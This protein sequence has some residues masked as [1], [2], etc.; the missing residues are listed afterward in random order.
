MIPLGFE[1]PEWLWALLLLVPVVA[2]AWPTRRVLSRVR[3]GAIL[4]ARLALLLALI[5]AL[6]GMVWYRH[7]DALAVVF[8]VDRSASLGLDGQE[9]GLKWVQEALAHQG[10][11]DLAG[12]VVFGAEAMVEAEPRPELALRGIEARPSP[13]Q[14][15]LAAG[16]RLGA[17]LIP[18]DRNGRIV[19]ISDGDETRG[20]AAAQVLLS[21]TEAVSLAVVPL[22]RASGPDVWLEDLLSPPRVDE[23]ASYE[24]RVVARASVPA[25]GQLRLYRN[26]EHLG[27]VP[28]TLR[29]DRAEVFTFRQ[30]ARVAGL[31]RYRAVFEPDPGITDVIPQNNEVMSTTQIMGRPR[32]LLVEG[33]PS[34]AKPLQAALT[35]QGFLVEVVDPAG[36]PAGPSG[37]RPYTALF[38][39]DVPAYTLS[40]RQQ[41]AVRSYVRDM[42]RGLVMIGGEKSFG[43]GGY[44]KSPIEQALP[45]KMDV[46]DK[47]RFPRVATVI[48]LDKSCSMG[49]G[50][51][52]ALGMAKEAGIQTVELLS[53]RDELGV[54]GFD[55]AASWIVPLLPLEDKDAVSR[56]IASI[57]SGGGTEIY[58]ALDR[59]IK[60]LKQ[61][62]AAVRHLILISD[63]GT[64]PGD[65]ETLIRGARKNDITLTS[66]AVGTYADQQ[67]MRDFAKWGGG[68]YYLV[69][70][71]S[72]IPAVFTREMMLASGSFL[73]EDPFTPQL[74]EPSD[75]TRGIAQAELRT[76]G[77]FVA[78]TAK[79]R[80]TLAMVAPGAEGQSALPLLAHWRF[81][82]G[83]SVAFTSDAKARWAKDWLGA[84]VYNRLWGQ[85]GRWTAGDIAGGDL[86][87]SAEIR[88]GELVVSV[89]A[90]DERGDF[91]NFLDGEARVI[92]PDLTVRPLALKQVSP[93]R[94]EARA[95]VDQ[96]GSWLAG[97]QLRD[98]EAV[99]GQAVAEAVQP[100]SPEYRARGG[101]AGTLTE[102]ARLG[103]GS[104][105]QDPAAAFERPTSLRQIP[106]PLWPAWLTLAGL[107]LLL[108]VAAR[109]LSW[110]EAGTAVPRPRAAPAPRPAPAAAPASAP[111]A[112]VDDLAIEPAAPPEVV[113]APP[114]PP[115]PGDDTYVGG[116]LA[117][118]QKARQRNQREEP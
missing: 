22:D 90:F 23:G 21:A 40:Q 94:Y 54:I 30:E 3:F 101:G 53:H 17:A 102:L 15:D 41:D 117:A 69:T 37:L 51:G 113:E 50:N 43:P 44:Y 107:L 95:P 26:Q 109:R 105:V 12:V 89:D 36:L 85:I 67:I 10:R 1:R 66:V 45:V 96:D 74:S 62:E 114:P 57:R 39:S 93:G 14:S 18:A 46:E 72:T 116:L 56:T 87:V 111:A 82:L 118:R 71:P 76:L 64:A 31:A 88:E 104:V 24:I 58:P 19:L 27:A 49:E 42:G 83:R 108:D 34:L 38:L 35:E 2:F 84:P 63:G 99:V 11:D 86:D 91:R 68:A 70:D 7:A 6:A 100:Y 4:S 55:G 106:E 16:L 60:G 9:K 80:A 65:F 103:G 48:A 110:G 33:E 13:H 61:S 92:A 25:K 32:V 20:D 97:V 112:P 115:K 79:P 8:V 75:L 47:T 29:D 81:G 77:G 28:V 73:L 52:S 59:S 78:T 5:F 98:G